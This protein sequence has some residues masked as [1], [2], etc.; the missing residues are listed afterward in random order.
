MRGRVLLPQGHR[1]C[2]QAAW[3]LPRAPRNG[4]QEEQQ[5]K[6]RL[7]SQD[8]NKRADAYPMY[9]RSIVKDFGRSQPLRGPKFNPLNKQW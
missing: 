3:R 8:A 2:G 1:R 9:T 7:R 5:R 6:P 4:E